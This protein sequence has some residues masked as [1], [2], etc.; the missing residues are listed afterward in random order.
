MYAQFSDTTMIT[1]EIEPPPSVN[2]YGFNLLDYEDF[3]IP[4]ITAL[5]TSKN[6]VIGLYQS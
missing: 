3:T 1:Y 2:K 5:C 6:V 4:Y